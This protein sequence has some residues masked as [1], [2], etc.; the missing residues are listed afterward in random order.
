MQA[1]LSM[2]HILSQVAV[3]S[4]QSF[5]KWQ[6]AVQSYSDRGLLSVIGNGA[7]YLVGSYSILRIFEKESLSGNP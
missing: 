2:R 3:Y 5:V 4:N 6:V 1:S 7:V